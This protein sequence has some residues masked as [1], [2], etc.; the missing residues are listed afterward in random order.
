MRYLGSIRR[1][2]LPYSLSPSESIVNMKITRL[3]QQ[4]TYSALNLV[5]RLVALRGEK[6][7][8][9]IPFLLPAYQSHHSI[10]VAG[11]VSLV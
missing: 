1:R 10:T 8:S 6:F 2:V 9:P 7:S 4:E 3:V 5:R 11:V